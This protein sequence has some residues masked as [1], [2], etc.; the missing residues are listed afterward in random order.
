MYIFQIESENELCRIWYCDS[1]SQSINANFIY[2]MVIIIINI[3]CDIKMMVLIYLNNIR[4]ELCFSMVCFLIFK[5][6]MLI[7]LHK[8]NKK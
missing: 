1:S 7:N 8:H 6:C 3:K 2:L 4:F 5:T